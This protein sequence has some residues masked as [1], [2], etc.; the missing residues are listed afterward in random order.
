[1]TQGQARSRY[2]FLLAVRWFP[3]GLWT[4]LVVLLPLDRGLTL[5]Q[6]GLAASLQGFVVLALE[7]P[8]GGLSDSWGRRPVLVLSAAVAVASTALLVFA[9]TFAMFALVYVMQGVYRALDSGPLDAWYIDATLDADPDAKLERGLGHGA[10]VIGLSIA[11]GALTTGAVVAWVRT[12]GVPTLVQPLLIGLITQLVGLVAL[13]LLVTEPARP[14]GGLLL[15]SLRDVPRVIADGVRLVRG[16]RVL[17]ALLLVELSWGFGMVTFEKLMAVRLSEVVGGLEK[18]ASLA[19]PAAAA[20]WF[21]SAA[22]A[23]L[24]PPVTARIGI[25]VTAV[26]LRVLQGV[27]VVGMGLLAGPA[28]VIAGYLATYLV[29]GA[30]NPVHNTLLHREVTGDLRSTVASMNSMVGQPGFA[31]GAILLT[32]LASGVSTGFAIV[33]G[34]VVLAL[35]APLYLPAVRAERRRSVAV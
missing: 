15:A 24:V 32:A 13:V 23:A 35:A 28:G 26:L 14:R 31:V 27:T 20:A 29:H 10:T 16:S 34:A 7:L 33:V 6:A 17:L 4:P 30:S 11:V 19:S 12:P 25:G 9:D 18:A 2:L 8:T 1:M 5:T 22:G 21:A 3:V